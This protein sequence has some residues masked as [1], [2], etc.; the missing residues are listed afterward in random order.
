MKKLIGG[1]PSF[2]HLVEAR[3]GYVRA[4]AAAQWRWRRGRDVFPMVA[5]FPRLT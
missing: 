3:H 2:N 4:R 1:C 5:V